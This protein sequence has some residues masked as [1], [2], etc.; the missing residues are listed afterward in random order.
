[1]I[2]NPITYHP[3]SPSRPTLL[4][5]VK[6]LHTTKAIVPASSCPCNHFQHKFLSLLVVREPS[7]IG[8]IPHPGKL[9]R[10]LDN[11]TNMLMLLNRT[12]ND[13]GNYSLSATI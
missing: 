4:V 6:I 1:M 9:I 11:L 5:R 7:Y 10:F 12:V 2:L 8:T 3:V 13:D